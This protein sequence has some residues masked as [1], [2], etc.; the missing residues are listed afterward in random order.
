MQEQNQIGYNYD[1]LC[2]VVCINI[3]AS[4][5]LSI[6]INIVASTNSFS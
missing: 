6:Q 2:R 1:S 3:A 4:T 5:N